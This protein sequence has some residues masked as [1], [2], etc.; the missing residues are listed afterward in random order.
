[1]L[2]QQ[3]ELRN[4]NLLFLWQS[5][6]LNQVGTRAPSPFSVVALVDVIIILGIILLSLLIN[7]FRDYQDRRREE[8]LNNLA[9]EL[10]EIAWEVNR[11]FMLKRRQFFETAEERTIILINGLENFVEEMKDQYRDALETTV[12]SA[13]KIM[14]S[15]QDQVDHLAN[16]NSDLA[17]RQKSYLDNL[18]LKLDQVLS[19]ISTK[20]D[21]WTNQLIEAGKTY[22]QQW[23]QI[24]LQWREELGKLNTATNEQMEHIM[25]LRNSFGVFR[26]N[27]KTF[28]RAAQQIVPAMEDLTKT[29]PEG[30]TGFSKSQSRL[31]DSLQG[32]EGSLRSVELVALEW[33]KEMDRALTELRD[34]KFTDGGNGFKG[35]DGQSN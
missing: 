29:I 6:T 24:I 25:E 1:M 27:M 4:E 32:V 17:S 11:I 31:I 20:Q 28:Q 34:I 14:A 18:T 16:Q 3:P 2:N 7:L 5:G 13:E 30:L 19:K 15:V 8:I 10:G 33:S 22:K 9:V 26:D 21:E 23:D 12:R 35:N